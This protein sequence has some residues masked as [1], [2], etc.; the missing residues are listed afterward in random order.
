M[1]SYRGVPSELQGW[2]TA[3]KRKQTIYD[4]PEMET[5]MLAYNYTEGGHL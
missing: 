2:L 1:T 4:L 3:I 5:V